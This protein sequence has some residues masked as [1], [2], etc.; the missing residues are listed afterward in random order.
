MS[1]QIAREQI[2]DILRQ[3]EKPGRYTGD[4]WNVIVKN[5]D[6]ERMSVALVFPD[7]YE[8]GMSN[9]G[10]KILY[11]Y[12]NKQDWAAAERVFS[13]GLDME[14]ALRARELPLFSLE[15]Y[16]PLKN[17]DVVGF[18]LQYE[19]SY[20]NVLNALDLGGIP[21]KSEARGQSDPIV[22]AGG[23]NAF[24]PEPLADYIDVFV[25]GEGEYVTIELLEKIKAMQEWQLERGALL[26]ELAKIEG[27]YV[28]RFYQE[29]YDG[30]GTYQGLKPTD[31]GIP[32]KITKRMISDLDNAEYPTDLI[33][34]NIDIVHD[35][36]FVELFRGCT[37]GCRFCQAG[38]IYRPVRE[39]SPQEVLRLAKQMIESTGYEEL[40]L[41]SLSTSDYNT[42]ESLVDRLNDCFTP[43]PVSLSLPSLRADAFSVNLAEKVQEGKKTGL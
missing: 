9:V 29:H 42:I 2:Q 33:V 8:V 11:H 17:F 23:P 5:D 28:P 13:P 38:F 24:T 20:T 39:R 43:N 1:Q 34:P 16:T 31:I 15:T 41:T 3:V 35:R 14:E 37:R 19:L 6:L 36:S 27:V 10:L 7:I 21:V 4:E 30:S 18:S 32:D 12:I 26:Y 22:I 40:S 25:I